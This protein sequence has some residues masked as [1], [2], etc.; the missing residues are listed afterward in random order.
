MTA[1][2]PNPSS[3]QREA[4]CQTVQL[5]ATGTTEVATTFGEKRYEPRQSGG[6]CSSNDYSLSSSHFSCQDSGMGN[7]WQKRKLII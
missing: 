3:V 5:R 6:V 7:W 2:L 1:L 4:E